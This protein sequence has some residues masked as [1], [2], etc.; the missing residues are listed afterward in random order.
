MAHQN[1]SGTGVP[2]DV[3]DNVKLTNDTFNP[4]RLG[5]SGG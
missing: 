1:T 2:S 5:C 4:E 3:M